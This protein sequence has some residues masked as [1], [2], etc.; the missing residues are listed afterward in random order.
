MSATTSDTQIIVSTLS[1]VLREAEDLA[2]D[3]VLLLP[4]D[5]AAWA[6]D[7]VAVVVPGEDLDDNDAHLEATMRGLRY[8]LGVSDVQD[9]KAN[10]LAQVQDASPELL[11]DALRFYFA[12]DAYPTLK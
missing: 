12:H 1:E 11:L 10:V 9:V 7:S 5:A 2:W 3:A 8:A 6:I 4:P